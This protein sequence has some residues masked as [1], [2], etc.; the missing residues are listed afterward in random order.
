MPK[1]FEDIHERQDGL[2]ALAFLNIE[3]EIK[4]DIEK[5]VNLFATESLCKLLLLYKLRLFN[6]VF[7]IIHFI[8]K[9][10]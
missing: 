9:C 3:R 8:K 5:A 4:I 2:S 10:M 1:T 7:F 6:V